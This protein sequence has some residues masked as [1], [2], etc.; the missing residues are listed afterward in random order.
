MK[1]G[2]RGIQGIALIVVVVALFGVGAWAG[3]K[4]APVLRSWGLDGSES[5]VTD[6]TTLIH[7]SFADMAELTTESYNFTRVGKWSQQGTTVL[8]VQVPGTGAHYLITYSGEVKAGL[9]DMSQIQVEVDEEN[10]LVTVTVPGVE[11]LSSSIDPNSIETHDQ[12]Y[13]IVNQIEVADV[14][15]FLAGQEAAASEEAVSKGLGILFIR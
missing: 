6:K 10:H 7:N 5:A 13:N 4:A 9:A 14:T 11:V 15:T 2:V 3:V 12:S 8:G 1:I